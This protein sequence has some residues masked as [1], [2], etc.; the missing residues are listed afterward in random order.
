[1][2]KS[3]DRLRVGFFATPDRDVGRDTGSTIRVDNTYYNCSYKMLDFLL[4]TYKMLVR[5]SAVCLRK[6]EKTKESNPLGLLALLM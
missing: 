2:A 5:I 1:M 6:I 3:M 4:R